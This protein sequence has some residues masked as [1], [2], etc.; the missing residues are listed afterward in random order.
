MSPHDDPLSVAAT[1]PD[2][3]VEKESGAHMKPASERSQSPDASDAHAITDGYFFHHAAQPAEHLYS[4][5]STIHA[6]SPVKYI[7]LTFDTEIPQLPDLHHTRSGVASIRSAVTGT[8][9]PNLKKFESPF[10]WSSTRKMFVSTVSFVASGLAAYSAGSYAMATPQLTKEW[11]ISLVAANVGITVFVLGFGFAPMILAPFSEVKGRYWVFVGAGV[12][13]WVGTMGCAVTRSFG[14]MLVSRFIVGNGASVFATLVGG[15]VSDIFHKDQRNTPMSLYS[16]SVFIGT[17]LGP[18]FSGVISDH[19]SWR[20]IF[21]LQMI[22][23]GFV[24]AMIALLFGETRGNVILHQKANALNKYLEA[25]ERDG[26]TVPIWPADPNVSVDPEKDDDSRTQHRR[27]RY[28]AAAEKH[29]SLPSMIW[30][31]FKFPFRLIVTESFVFWFSLWIS[32]AWAILYMQFSS[33]ALVFRT[34][35]NFSNTRIGAVFTSVIVG[36][37]IVTFMSIYQEKLARR[38]WTKLT[39]TPEGRLYFACVESA[40][41][42]IGLF[43]FGWTSSRSIHW[44]VPTLAVGCCTIGIFSIYLAVFSYLADTYHRYASSALAAQSMCRNVLAGVFPLV[45]GYLFTN[46]TYPGAG[47][48]LGG[49]GVLL[50]AV[51]WVLVFWGEKIR[52]RSPL[53]GEIMEHGER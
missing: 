12:T 19:L 21:Y 42:P 30:F 4:D 39:T 11:H 27:V 31:S 37:I 9:S 28:R 8:S 52:R 36:S 17:G 38:Y 14:G 13:F 48:L 1:Q 20:W 18:M 34:N 53:A 6:H 32:F 51:P 7:E 23:I 35:H 49:I 45:T 16:L 46:L 33:I 15:V 50:T 10:H 25:L 44:I 5:V 3:A 41:L 24:V 29:R 47:S 43:W 22:M 40:F 26:Q 2:P